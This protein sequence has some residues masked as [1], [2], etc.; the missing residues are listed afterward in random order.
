MTLVSDR[1]SIKLENKMIRD[2]RGDLSCNIVRMPHLR[3][4]IPSEILYAAFGE[5]V[6]TRVR[7]ANA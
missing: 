6:S 7:T 1:S 3:I 5:E 2:K 4:S